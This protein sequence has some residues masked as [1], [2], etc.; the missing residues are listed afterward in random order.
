MGLEQQ[1]GWM[2]RCD[3]CNFASG[4]YETRE[5]ALVIVDEGACSGFVEE[6]E[7]R[8]LCAECFRV[9]TDGGSDDG[10]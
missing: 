7:R 3:A 5:A 4:P 9:W 8:W 6:G 10:S 2:L 1:T